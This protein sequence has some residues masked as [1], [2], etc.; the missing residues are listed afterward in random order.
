MFRRE[1]VESVGCFRDPW[2]ADDLDFYLWVARQYPG[3]CYE[4]AFYRGSPS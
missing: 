4:A 2:G 3:W 1:A